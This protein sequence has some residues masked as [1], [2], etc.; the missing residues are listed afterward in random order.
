MKSIHIYIEYI[1]LIIIT[2]SV[3]AY[4]Y[5]YYQ[6]NKQTIINIFKGKKEEISLEDINNYINYIINFYNSSFDFVE[7]INGMC[8]RNYTIFYKSSFCYPTTLNTTYSG[9]LIE[10]NNTYYFYSNLT[11]LYYLVEPMSSISFEGCYNGRPSYIILSTNCYGFCKNR[12]YIKV[13][14]TGKNLSIYIS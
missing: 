5:F 8:I 7:N 14:K 3:L 12:C 4:I 1:L 9:D 2:L 11:N 10:I 6:N 13:E